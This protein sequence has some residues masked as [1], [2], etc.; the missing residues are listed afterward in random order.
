[1]GHRALCVG[2]CLAELFAAASAR[3]DA[4]SRRQPGDANIPG[5]ARP[6]KQTDFDPMLDSQIDNFVEFRAGEHHYAT[7]L[8]DPMDRNFET[9]S[10]FEKRTKRLRPFD[11]RDLDP[12]CAAVGETRVGCQWSRRYRR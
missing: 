11:G 6:K 12:K 4:T 5:A 9:M 10:Q 3:P 7:A 8:A 2:D 1:M